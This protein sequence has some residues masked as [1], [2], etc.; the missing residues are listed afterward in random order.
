MNAHV[1]DT[2]PPPG[3]ASP[4]INVCRMDPRTGWCEGCRRT[5]EEIAHWSGMDAAARRA[6]WAALATRAC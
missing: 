3:I 5:I 1:N 6:V 4:C 2:E